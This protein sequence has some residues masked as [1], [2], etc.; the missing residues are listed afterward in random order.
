MTDL[1]Y[2]CQV[3]KTKTNRR[4]MLALGA[5]AIAMPGMSGLFAA[6]AG[7]SRPLDILI[8]GGTGFF[9]PHQIKYALARGH[10]LTLFNRGHEDAATIYGNRVEVLIGD[11]DVKTSP[12][13]AALEGTRRWDAVIDNS[14]Y[15]PRHVRDSAQLLKGRVGRYL[16]VSTVAAYEGADPVCA[17][18]S[19]LRSLSNPENE[20]LTGQSYGEMKAE[21]DR[22]VRE[23]YGPAA[24]VVR[25]TYVVGPED[26]TDRFTYWVARAAEGGVVVGPR[27]DAKNLQTVDVRDLCPWM[28][29]LIERDMSGIFNAASP[30]VP[31]E[32]VLADL[33]PLSD[34]PVRF[35]RPPAD[36]LEELK[37]D[38]PLVAPTIAGGHLLNEQTTFDGR[39]AVQAG[40]SYRPLSDTGRA[41]LEWWRAQTPERRAA[42]T[43][44]WPTAEQEK[45]VLEHMSST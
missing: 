41:V 25:P 29:R 32:R 36:I 11:R 27:A 1:K 9:G 12:G 7:A 34:R 20:Q 10:H 24:I 43:K 22:I 45:A 37:L 2:V 5:A 13:L 15:V 14:G 42:A 18:T 19:P 30:P 3:H 16:Y 23:Q 33:R 31:W 17:E 35:V 44:Y 38:F 39:R 21:G 8:L 40:I 28:V 6:V 4:E 26:N